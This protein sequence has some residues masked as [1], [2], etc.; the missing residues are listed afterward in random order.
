MKKGF[1]LIELLVTITIFSIVLTI[2]TYFFIRTQRH[3]LRE[4]MKATL[5]EMTVVNLTKI[6]EKILKSDEILEIE[7]KKFVFRTKIGDHDSIYEEENHVIVNNQR[8]TSKGIDSIFFFWED[9]KSE[10]EGLHEVI[11]I[12][13]DG[14]LEYDE[15][16]NLRIIYIRYKVVKE[17]DVV[18]FSTSIYLRK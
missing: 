3:I 17:T 15:L 18:E 8:L 9:P 5:E 16:K 11:D 6:R 14:I 4:Q 12:D 2:V 10:D 1:S 7:E 13:E